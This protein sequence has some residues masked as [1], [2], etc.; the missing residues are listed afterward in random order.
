MMGSAE[1]GRKWTVRVC[2]ALV[3]LVVLACTTI[4]RERRTE[5]RGGKELPALSNNL[6]RDQALVVAQAVTSRDG[7][8]TQIISTPLRDS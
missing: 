1:F 5:L 6:S 7:S 3:L 8:P 2:G 4:V